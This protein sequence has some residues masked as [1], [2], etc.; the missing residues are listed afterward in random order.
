MALCLSNTLTNIQAHSS[1]LY[2]HKQLTITFNKLENLCIPSG[3]KVVTSMQVDKSACP[4]IKKLRLSNPLATH[5]V[6]AWLEQGKSGT[7]NRKSKLA[8]CTIQLLAISISIACRVNS[9]LLAVAWTDSTL[10]LRSTMGA[11]IVIVEA[12]TYLVDYIVS[13]VEYERDE[14][15]VATYIGR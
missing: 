14:D 6:E 3:K 4:A 5:S 12:D 2:T 1:K 9:S 13:F 10:C 8:T 11:N 7:G 15:A